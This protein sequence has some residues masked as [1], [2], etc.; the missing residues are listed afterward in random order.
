MTTRVCEGLPEARCITGITV[1]TRGVKFTLDSQ[2]HDTV[3]VNNNPKSL[4]YTDSMVYVK[5]VTSLFRLIRGF[6][7]HILYDGAQRIYISLAP[8]YEGKVS[9]L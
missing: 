7:F 3:Y 1:E 2:S 8:Y 4:P 5:K 6:S 9:F